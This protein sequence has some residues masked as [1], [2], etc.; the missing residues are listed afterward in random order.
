MTMVKLVMVMIPGTS[1]KLAIYTALFTWAHASHLIFTMFLK[2][3]KV[4][5]H[6]MTEMFTCDL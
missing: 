6:S 5:A 4:P 1:D 3:R 2:G